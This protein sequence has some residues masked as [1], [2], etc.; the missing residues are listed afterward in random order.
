MAAALRQAGKR[1]GGDV[2]Q[3]SRSAITSEKGRRLPARFLHNPTMATAA[4][5]STAVARFAEILEKKEELFDLVAD[6]HTTCRTPLSMSWGHSQ[7]LHRLSTQI[8]PRPMDPL[9]RACRRAQRETS[10]FTALGMCTA[11]ISGVYGL[12]WLKKKYAR[13]EVST[14]GAL[15]P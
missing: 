12:H 13:A 9:W 15:H 8:E 7:L 11:G 5:D 4:D 3:R 14:N 6:F 2:V 1:L 10:F